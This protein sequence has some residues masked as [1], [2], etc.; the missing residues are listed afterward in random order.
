VPDVASA[1]GDSKF[2]PIFHREGGRGGNVFGCF[3]P[4]LVS[5]RFAGGGGERS[6]IGGGF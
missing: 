1:W 2:I 5:S 6:E 4:P 3:Y